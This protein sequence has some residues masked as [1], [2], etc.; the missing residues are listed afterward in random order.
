MCDLFILFVLCPIGGVLCTLLWQ[1][2][3]WLRFFP[4][5]A[6]LLSQVLLFVFISFSNYSNSILQFYITASI[7][8][9]RPPSTIPKMS[10]FL[11]SK[12]VTTH[13]FHFVSLLIEKCLRVMFKCESKNTHWIAYQICRLDFVRSC[14]HAVSLGCFQFTIVW[15]FIVIY[16]H[17]VAN[18]ARHRSFDPAGQYVLI[19]ANGKKTHSI[20][21]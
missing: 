15:Y 18:V 2:S 10:P 17:A 14:A 21:F 11:H 19:T 1:A 9:N 5:N 8:I 12:V 7:Q 6:S 16:F 20:E 13:W 3:K 4:I